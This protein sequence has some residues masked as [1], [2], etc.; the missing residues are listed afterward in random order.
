MVLG[1][2]YTTASNAGFM[3]SLVAFFTPLIILVQEH[4]SLR[5]MLGIVLVFIGV[6]ITVRPKMMIRR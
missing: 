2:K 5:Q 4:I 6:W 3:M 1:C